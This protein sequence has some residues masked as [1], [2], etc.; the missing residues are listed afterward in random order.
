[1]RL[2]PAFGDSEVIFVTV[3]DRYESQVPSGCRFYVVNDA[4]RWDK[5]GL[6]KAALRLLWIEVKERPDVIV[7]TGAAHGYFAVYFGRFLG[8]R[9]VW[10]DSMA[11][12][13]HL[14]TSGA[15]A[16]RHADLWLTQWPH[17]A[18]PQGPHYRG[19]VL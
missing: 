18:K 2:T 8:A 4:T 19:S 11:N 16:G 12:A 9:T 6:I 15:R 7:S 3:N 1:M 14:S 13:E 17:L 5:V 10:I